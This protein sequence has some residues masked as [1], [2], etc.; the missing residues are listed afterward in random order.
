MTS[1]SSVTSCKIVRAG[2]VSLV[3]FVSALLSGCA[4][5]RLN[6]SDRL[7]AHPQFRDAARAAPV[8]TSDALK[9]INRLEA[10]IERR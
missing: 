7:I 2:F 3:C 5:V 1:V 10:E 4:T 6:N 8:W 9:T